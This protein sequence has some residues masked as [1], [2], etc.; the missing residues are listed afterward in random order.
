MLKQR[1]DAM[2]KSSFLAVE[3]ADWSSPMGTIDELGA[4]IQLAGC[5]TAADSVKVGYW[6]R[7]NRDRVAAGLKF[8][9][10]N[11]RSG[12]VVWQLRQMD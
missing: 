12:S 2:G 1:A 10:L 7:G 11:D 3:V 6:L 4:A 8:E 9:R 5:A